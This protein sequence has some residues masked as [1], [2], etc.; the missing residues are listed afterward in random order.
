V[1]GEGDNVQARSQRGDDK[2]EVVMSSGGMTAK[3]KEKG[4]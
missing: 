4:I 1:E 3:G 2:G